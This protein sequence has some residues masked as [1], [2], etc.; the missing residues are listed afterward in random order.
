MKIYQQRKEEKNRN[1]KR[2]TEEEWEQHFTAFLH[3]RKE[4]EGKTLE[5]RTGTRDDTKED[6]TLEEMKNQIRKLKK[7]KAAW[8][9]YTGKAKLKL[10]E[11][12]QR[13]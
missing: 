12:T 6:I 9:Y 13:V 3:G 1:I 8:L 5:V 2:I 10:L 7:K 11:I 4:K